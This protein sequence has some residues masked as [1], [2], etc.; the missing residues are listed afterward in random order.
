MHCKIGVI[1]WT[2]KHYRIP[3]KSSSI[4]AS[5]CTIQLHCFQN[6]L[7]KSKYRIKTY[8]IALVNVLVFMFSHFPYSSKSF[9]IPSQCTLQIHN[10]FQLFLYSTKSFQIPPECI[11]QRDC[12][13]FISAVPNRFRYHQNAYFIEIVF[14][15]SL[16]FQIVSDITIMHALETLHMCKK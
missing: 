7:C 2:R 15:L 16:Q 3:L 12:F 10:C 9:L 4:K 5:D 14:M 8:H 6:V 11:L 13:H 1:Q